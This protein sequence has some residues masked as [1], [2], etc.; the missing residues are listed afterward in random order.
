MTAA[1]NNAQLQPDVIAGIDSACATSRQIAASFM[2]DQTVPQDHL[3]QVSPRF[4]YM[5]IIGEHAR[6]AGQTSS[7]PLKGP[8]NEPAMK[9]DIPSTAWAAGTRL[10]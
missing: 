6:H 3:G 9:S 1:P 10:P 7:G 5:N 4:M 2:L 8:R